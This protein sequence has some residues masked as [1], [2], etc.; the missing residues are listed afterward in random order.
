V[1][2]R[3]LIDLII[4]KARTDVYIPR[5]SGRLQ[6]SMRSVKVSNNE[7]KMVV[8]TPY[9][10]KINNSKTRSKGYIERTVKMAERLADE[11]FLELIKRDLIKKFGGK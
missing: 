5:R 2:A 8:D 4:Y 11:K 3:N 1:A 10:V 9:A 7:A 6:R